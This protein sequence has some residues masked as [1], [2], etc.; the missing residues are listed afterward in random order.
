[1]ISCAKSP[2]QG[3]YLWTTLKTVAEG[4]PQVGKPCWLQLCGK[5]QGRKAKFVKWMR[6]NMVRLL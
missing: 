2:E 3:L 6:K 4:N 5:Q 1:M